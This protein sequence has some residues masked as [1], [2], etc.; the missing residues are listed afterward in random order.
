MHVAER[1]RA[2]AEPVTDPH[3]A[4]PY[5]AE[6]PPGQVQSRGAANQTGQLPHSAAAGCARAS[7]YFEQIAADSSD[8]AEVRR[9]AQAA[10]E[11]VGRFVPD[12]MRQAARDEVAR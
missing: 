1:K 9:L 11:D 6:P 4:Q 10:L 7:A 8:P 5:P 2:S 12:P 3:P